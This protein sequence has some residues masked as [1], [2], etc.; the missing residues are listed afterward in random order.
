MALL[1]PLAASS[2]SVLPKSFAAPDSGYS[3]NSSIDIQ[4]HDNAVW[5][6]TDEGLS[7]TYDQGLSWQRFGSNTGL[8]SEIVSAMYSDGQR[9]WT[10]TSHSQQYD[11]ARY[12][13]SDGISYS[14]DNGLSW[15]WIDLEGF[16]DIRY[17][18][19]PYTTVYDLT[20]HIDQELD[21][22]W[23]FLS[24][25]AGGF[26]ASR[27]GGVTWRRI[28]PSTTDSV[29]F[30]SGSSLS[31]RNKGFSCVADS[32]RQDSLF[33]WA[34]TAGGIFQYIFAGPRNKAASPYINDI[35][36]CDDCTDSSF[37]F[38]AGNTS[39]TRGLTTGR[40]YIS[41]FDD[42]GLPGSAASALI[43]YRGRI[44]AGTVDSGS[45]NLAGLAYSDDKGDSYTSVGLPLPMVAGADDLI[46]EFASIGERLYLAAE[47]NGLFTS[48]DTGLT[49]VQIL[50]DSAQTTSLRNTANGLATIGD[51]LLVGT[52]T[53]LA[54]LYLD[55]S[56]S[57]D[58]LAFFTFGEFDSSAAYVSSTTI[59]RVRVQE[60]TDEESGLVDSVAY[61]TINEPLTDDGVRMVARR[62]GDSTTWQH[63]QWRVKMYDVGFIGDTAIV[64]SE[65]GT[66]YTA[67]GTNPSTAFPIEK[68][69]NGAAIDS[70][71]NDIVTTMAVK[72]DTVIFGSNNGHAISTDRG[73]EFAIYRVNTDPM[74][75]DLV[76]GYTAAQDLWRGLTGDFI[77]S[78]AVQSVGEGEPGRLWVSNRSTVEWPNVN[79]ISIGESVPVDADGDEVQPGN[80]IDHY[81][82]QW[83]YVN[84]TTFAWNFAFHDSVAFAATDS[85]LLKF[86]PIPGGGWTE[87]TIPLQDSLGVPLILDGMAVY[88]VAVEPP[89]LWVATSDRTVRIR[90]DDYDDQ[91]PYMVIDSTTSP[92]DVYAFPVPFSHNL[93]A[94]SGGRLDFHFVVDSPTDV[95][96]KIYD[97]AMNLVATVI[98]SQPFP[99]GI[100]PTIGSFRPTWDGINDKGVRAAIG[101]YY[102]KVELSSGD[103]RWGKL[104]LIP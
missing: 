54:T 23:V 92:D 95:T 88:G 7:A 1:V 3:S 18:E 53:G 81:E 66:W 57:I 63:F 12:A 36:F 45:G 38:Y 31:D 75:P 26:L 51:T 17:I 42:D 28:F 91:T 72:G 37:V 56:G 83:E 74:I 8:I 100:Y 39:A 76:I 4:L 24:S 94:S 55:A 25:W 2:Q 43:Y 40:P 35:A 50:V 58:S 85:G 82:W 80:E 14:D 93:D 32:S 60:F 84:S 62:H 22:N 20:G 59:R 67:N 9:L 71:G 33:L 79:A 69:Y 27:D 98:E 11:G 5:L 19:G 47:G 90:L 87:T 34:G 61:W 101:V 44:L 41:R 89:Y 102:F 64:M 99:A 68:Y 16:H 103:T 70:L 49:W 73:Q 15:T 29:Q 65:S 30:Y 21:A 78:M 10:A 77:P 86:D 96:I 46:T 52:D 13:Y 48:I 97:F 104:A 6:A